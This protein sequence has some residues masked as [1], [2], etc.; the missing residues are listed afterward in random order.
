MKSSV[1]SHD[2]SFGCKCT[3]RIEKMVRRNRGLTGIYPCAL[4]SLLMLLSSSSS[5]SSFSHFF[6]FFKCISSFF[7]KCISSMVMILL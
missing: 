2:P 1:F 3:S 6:F 7:F 4:P 5:S